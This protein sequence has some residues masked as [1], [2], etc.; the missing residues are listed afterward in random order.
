MG[1]KY[2]NNTSSRKQMEKYIIF[3]LGTMYP[4]GLNHRFYWILYIAYVDHIKSHNLTDAFHFIY[5]I[6]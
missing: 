2:T 1:L 5:F 6:K 3:K 4:N